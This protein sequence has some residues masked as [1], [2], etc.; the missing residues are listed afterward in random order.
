[1]YLV[2]YILIV[3]SLIKLVNTLYKISYSI[4]LV[5]IEKYFK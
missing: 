2:E 4:V 3:N 1:M 5:I